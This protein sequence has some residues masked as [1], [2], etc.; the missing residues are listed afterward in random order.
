MDLELPNQL[1]YHGDNNTL[2][3][4]R[5]SGFVF[6]LICFLKNPRTLQTK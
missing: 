4:D 1:G 5:P 3:R 6:V 2:P